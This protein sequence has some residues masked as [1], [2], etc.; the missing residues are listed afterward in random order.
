MIR[1]Y[2]RARRQLINVQGCRAVVTLSE[3]M[4]R[5]Y[6]R[7]GVP[8]ARV[9]CIPF[10]PAPGSTGAAESQAPAAE[11]TR[12]VRLLVV[13]RLERPKG[14]HLA[15]D[16]LPFIAASLGRPVQLTVV[17]DGRDR[18][19]LGAQASAVQRRRPDV[20]VQ[21]SGWLAPEDRDRLIGCSDLLVV[22]SAWAEP[23]GIVGVEAGRLGL[24]AVAFDIGGMSQWLADGVNGA[25]APASPPTAAG[26]AAAVVRCLDGGHHARLRAGARAMAKHFTV[27]EHVSG[28]V[29]VLAGAGARSGRAS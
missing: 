12:E 27:E 5:E 7:Q 16:A 18:P 26:L 11:R 19:A 4:R 3:H 17:G 9:H 8:P 13:A 20:R 22:P 24:P 14:V 21:F 25:L 28:L 1:L 6:L 15:L 23:F 10:G 29:D 2:Q